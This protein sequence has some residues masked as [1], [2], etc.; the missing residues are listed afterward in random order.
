[1][2]MTTTTT[3]TTKN[4]LS[5]NASCLR[6][7]VNLSKISKLYK[8]DKQSWNKKQFQENVNQFSP[9]LVSLINNII[10]LDKNDK[11]NHQTFF[12]HL[13]FTDLTSSLHGAKLLAGALVALGCEIY[14]EP[15]NR[16]EQ[17][18]QQSDDYKTFGLL[19]KSDVFEKPI[20]SKMKLDI[21]KT[22]NKRPDNIYGKN[23]RFLILDQSFK[24][25]IDAFDVKYLHLFEPLKTPQEL[26]QVLG[27]ATRMCGQKG[28]SFDVEKGWPLNVF[29]YDLTLPQSFNN[30]TAHQL[31]M[32]S[33]GINTGLMNFSTELEKIVQYGSIDFSLTENIHY[34][35]N[36]KKD[37]NTYEEYVPDKD[38][39]NILIG[40]PMRLLDGKSSNN[41]GRLSNVE[42][43][44]YFKYRNL[45]TQVVG[46]DGKFLDTKSY[47]NN[48]YPRGDDVFEWPAIEMI[49]KCNLPSHQTRTP[50]TSTSIENRIAKLNPTQMLLKDY[51]KPSSI[52]KG[53]FLW[54]S[55]G[56]GKTCSAISM[57]S[58]FEKTHTILWVT[59]SSLVDDVFKNIYKTVCSSQIIEKLK[60]GVEISENSKNVP[61]SKWMR[62][63]GYK[64]FSNLLKKKNKLYAEMVKRN[65]IEDPLKN[66]L[67]VIDEVHKIFSNNLSKQE[68]P[69][70]RLMRKMIDNSYK[71]S[72]RNSARLILMSATPFSSTSPMDFI[73]MI[74]F[75]LEEK[76]R[77]PTDYASFQKEF[78]N[79]KT[80]CF[81]DKGSIKF[82]DTISGHIS[83]LNRSKDV[84]QFAYPVFHNIVSQSSVSQ[85]EE[86]KKCIKPVA[87][88]KASKKRNNNGL[89][90]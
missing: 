55:T 74:N 48:K 53:M 46:G 12:K 68:Q 33:I 15:R 8:F 80:N 40:T 36:S 35:K 9:K 84:S 75:L 71:T 32:D 14:I 27:R 7:V 64:T 45:K 47:I 5:L 21:L 28:L 22:F 39:L 51:F 88:A 63:I 62:P 4:D 83:Y 2:T 34:P 60:R 58:N 25:G 19:C 10:R 18:Q 37:K 44:E 49:N 42:K 67:I 87:A 85:N 54:H 43:S 65:G 31:Y 82:L 13:I 17:N 3:T 6:K 73:E 20:S 23:M 76:E 29:T 69:D 41:G 16:P 59:R 89:E 61:N 66:T 1:M 72:K 70:V 79:D 78:L 57:I 30:K 24:E 26:Q 56:S 81:T 90:Q 52:G 11:T 50:S 77:F 86:L 38:T